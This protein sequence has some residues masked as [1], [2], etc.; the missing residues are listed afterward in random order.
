[1]FLLT[2]N[3]DEDDSIA[4][5]LTPNIVRNMATA[6]SSVVDFSKFGNHVAF[7]IDARTKRKKVGDW[8]P[9]EN[10]YQCAVV[11]A[12]KEP[13]DG[14]EEELKSVCVLRKLRNELVHRKPTWIT[15]DLGEERYRSEESNIDK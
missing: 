7:L 1:L 8:T 3:C 2:N 10:K 12:G 9:T 4:A 15:Y 13:F 14:T 11:L 5:L 6:W